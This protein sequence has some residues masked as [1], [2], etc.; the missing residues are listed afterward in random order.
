MLQPGED[1][2]HNR[3]RVDF[4]LRIPRTFRPGSPVSSRS[5]DWVPA[6]GWS[7]CW[8]DSGSGIRRTQPSMRL[9]LLTRCRSR[10]C[11]G[12]GRSC[13]GGGGC[14]FQHH[15]V[16]GGEDV[17]A[18]DFPFPE[19]VSRSGVGLR[20]GVRDLSGVRDRSGVRRTGDWPHPD[21]SDPVLFRLALEDRVLSGAL[22]ELPGLDPSPGSTAVG[23]LCTTATSPTAS[24]S[25]PISDPGRT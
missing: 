13:L 10:C 7:L 24:Y 14:G 15:V 4:L 17:L 22:P 6:G 1:S 12:C 18:R 21:L 16:R 5:E 19:S 25:V 9:R 8:V 3:R 23:G 11:P 20:T 2:P